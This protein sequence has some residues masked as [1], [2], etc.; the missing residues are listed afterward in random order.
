M[1]SGDLAVRLQ[2]IRAAGFSQVELTAGDLFASLRGVEYT[3]DLLA[4]S[5]LRVC[6]YNL[7]RDYEGC[8]DSE[9]VRRT[10]VADQLLAQAAWLGAPLLVACSNTSPDA[11]S[12]R[13]RQVDDLRRLGDLAQARGLRIAYEALC[14]GTHIR[15]Y[16]R[17]WELVELADHPAVGLLLDSSHIGA[18]GL[19]MAGVREL[20]ARRV[21]HVQLADLPQARLS[22]TDLSRYYRLLPGQGALDMDGFMEALGFIGY[23]GALSLEVLSDHYRML[24]Q[25]EGARQGFD[26]VCSLLKGRP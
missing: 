14:W 22:T 15:D 21:F 12:D 17:A 26:A 1:F 8:A 18:L 13:R 5:G 10:E 23:A 16:R 20:D 2:A 19:P 25:A 24:P 4:Q 9:L 3:L 7:V 11:S 6:A